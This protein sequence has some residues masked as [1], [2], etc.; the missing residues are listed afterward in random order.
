MPP[1]PPSSTAFLTDQYELTML[2]RALADGSASRRCAFEV[3][4]RGLRGPEKTVKVEEFRIGGDRSGAGRGP[5]KSRRI[6]SQ[7][8]LDRKVVDGSREFFGSDQRIESSPSGFGRRFSDN[9]VGRETGQ[10]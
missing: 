8:F 1:C 9:V 6:P 3:F 5:G 2:A 7:E 4:A 10:L